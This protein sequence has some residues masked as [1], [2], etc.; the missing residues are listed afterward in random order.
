VLWAP[1]TVL[2]KAI[3]TAATW[4]AESSFRPTNTKRRSLTNDLLIFCRPFGRTQAN[5]TKGSIAL[6]Y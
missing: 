2:S 5:N 3:R 4:L 1:L 6:Y